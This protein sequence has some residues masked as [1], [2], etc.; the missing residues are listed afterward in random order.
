VTA[1]NAKTMVV[2]CGVELCQQKITKK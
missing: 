1:E 2:Q